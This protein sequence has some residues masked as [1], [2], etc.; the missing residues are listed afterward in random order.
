MSRPTLVLIIGTVIAFCGLFL[1]FEAHNLATTWQMLGSN[2]WGGETDMGRLG[3]YQGVGFI[4]LVFGLVLDVLA[5]QRWLN[6]SMGSP[7]P[8]NR[9][10]PRFRI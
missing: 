10:K 3:L 9:S 5:I 8:A 6:E 7:E 1:R 4:L 2:A